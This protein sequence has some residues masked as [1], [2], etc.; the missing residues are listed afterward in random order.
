MDARTPAH[1]EV[2]AIVVSWNSA[3]HLGTALAS[4]PGDVRAIVV[5]NASADASVAVA[6]EHGAEVIEMGRNVGFP[7]AVNVAL[8][9]VTSPTTLLLNPD[10]V[11]G[12]KAIERCLA[13]LDC[14]PTV[15]IVGP[16]TRT[17]DGRPEPAAA[18][19]DRRAWHIVVES[20]G[21]VHMSR[22]LDRQMIHNRARDRDVD[23]VNGAFMLVRTDVLRDLGGLDDSVFMY[24]EDADLC[25]RVRDAGLRVRFVAGA[26]A[27]HAGGASTARGDVGAQ[28]RAYLHRID[29]DLEFLRRYGRRG[30]PTLAITAYVFR[31]LL[32]I[33]V[34]AFLPQRRE[35]YRASLRY[36]LAQVHGRRPADAV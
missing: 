34:S 25:R 36:T 30:E 33:A 28:A 31:S 19:H 4:L 1:P 21:L 17:P 8:H 14:D 32:G 6:R 20:L 2:D 12:D 35:R 29:A 23:T 3:P 10:L 24:L 13:V 16:A 5:D 7:A 26:D 27:V 18:R 11:V 15:A 9:R 22:S